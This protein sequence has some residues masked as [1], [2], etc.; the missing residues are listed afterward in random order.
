MSALPTTTDMSKIDSITNLKLIWSYED[1]RWSAYSP[2]P[3]L[4]EAI[5]SLSTIDTITS[6]SKEKAYWVLT[7]NKTFINF[8]EN[9]T[10]LDIDSLKSGWSLISTPK[11]DDVKTKFKNR[12]KALWKYSKGVWY[13]YAPSISDIPSSLG[14]LEKLDEFDGRSLMEFGF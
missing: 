7:T 14:K 1:G 2:N 9:I 3:A 6:T 13:L 12:V 5:E 8:D 11:V 4:Q 10:S